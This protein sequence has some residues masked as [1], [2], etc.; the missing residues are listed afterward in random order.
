MLIYNNSISFYLLNFILD[1][2]ANGAL[3]STPSKD[4][5]VKISSV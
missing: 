5:T 3:V 2:R 1:V 4:K